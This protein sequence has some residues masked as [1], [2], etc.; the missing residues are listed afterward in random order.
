MND[1]EVLVVVY[2]SFWRA[3]LSL[4]LCRM[5]MVLIYMFG[6]VAQTM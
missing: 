6:C 2:R 4:G 5:S 3:L 1:R